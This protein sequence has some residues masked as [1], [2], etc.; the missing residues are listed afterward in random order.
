MKHLSGRPPRFAPSTARTGAAVIAIAVALLAGACSGTAAS[1][2]GGGPANAA[3]SANSAL[4]GFSRCMRS[5][6]VRNFPDPE[7]GGGD[8]KFPSARQLGVSSSQYQASENACQHLLPV[9]LDDQFPPAEVALLLTG[10]REFS[11]CMRSHGVSNWPDPTV[12]SAGQPLFDLGAQGITRSQA[13]SQHIVT[14]EAECQHLLPS[15]LGGT[16]IG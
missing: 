10:M 14:T 4:V 11:E 3:D 9:G 6:G 13:H 12:N 1:L 16:P 5:Q 2:S 7:P 8:A 15:A